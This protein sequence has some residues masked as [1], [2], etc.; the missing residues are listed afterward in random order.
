MLFFFFSFSSSEEREP[1]RSSLPL[2]SRR[3]LFRPMKLFSKSLRSPSLALASP[4]RPSAGP[5][6]RQG[7]RELRETPTHLDDGRLVVRGEGRD[8]ADSERALGGVGA[9]AE[10]AGAR[11]ERRGGD[12][13]S[14]PRRSGRGRHGG[15]RGA[16]GHGSGGGHFCGVWWKGRRWKEGDG[17]RWF[18]RARS[19]KV[20]LCSDVFGR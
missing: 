17:R 8:G 5:L 13:G 18:S 3:F 14:A 10:K 11:G 1:R 6:A 9:A 2:A 20:I 19:E 15:E 7:H 4:S 16:R 12:G